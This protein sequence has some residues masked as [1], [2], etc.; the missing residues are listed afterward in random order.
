MGRV[1]GSAGPAARGASAS[2]A[3]RGTTGQARPARRRGRGRP[4]RGQAPG[5]RCRR[6]ASRSRVGARG[7]PRARGAHPDGA[8]EPR[9]KDA[10]RPLARGAT[11]LVVESVLLAA[12][13]ARGERDGQ[14]EEGVG[15]LAH[16]CQTE[17]TSVDSNF[18]QNSG[19]DRPAAGSAPREDRGATLPYIGKRAAS[20]WHAGIHGAR[21][22][23]FAPIPA[24]FPQRCRQL[25]DVDCGHGPPRARAPFAGHS[26]LRPLSK[27]LSRAQDSR[28]TGEAY[29]C[30]EWFVDS[31]RE[32]G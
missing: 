2:R 1:S 12:S 16:A 23:C 7:A 5:R 22:E 10:V 15:A 14:G 24:L 31:R 25:A 6:R 26:P 19:P 11:A 4:I 21:R 3:R 28:I 8:L 18:S 27:T 30:S 17:G 13:A 29:K 20:R 9:L 32:W